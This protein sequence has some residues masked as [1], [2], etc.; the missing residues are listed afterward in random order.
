[1]KNETNNEMNLNIE[2]GNRNCIHEQPPKIQ[3][4]ESFS[5]I[6]YIETSK[7]SCELDQDNVNLF[8]ISEP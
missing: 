7:L 2:T 8:K 1:M 3:I 4:D 5:V 6:I